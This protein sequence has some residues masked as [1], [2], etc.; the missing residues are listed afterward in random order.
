MSSACQSKHWHRNFSNQCWPW[1][2]TPSS[3]IEKTPYR[4]LHPLHKND[5]GTFPNYEAVLTPAPAA[6]FVQEAPHR[7]DPTKIK[8]GLEIEKDLHDI[9]IIEPSKSPY[10]CNTLLTVKDIPFM[11]GSNT[12][13]DRHISKTDNNKQELSERKWRYTVDQRSHN[14]QLVPAQ[15]DPPS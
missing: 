1:F 9:G 14:A 3:P 12:L 11:T 6:R 4:S 2:P 7:H 15:K 10:P 8:V 13:A 5:V